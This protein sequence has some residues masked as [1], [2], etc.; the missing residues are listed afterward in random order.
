MPE[1]RTTEATIEQLARWAEHVNICDQFSDTFLGNLGRQCIR[2]FQIDENSRRDWLESLNKAEERFDMKVVEKNYPWPKAANVKYPILAVAVL[3]FAARAYSSIIPSRNVVKGKVLGKDPEGEKRARAERIGEH[4][5]Y[6]LLDVIEDW[7][8]ETDIMVHQLPLA[9]CVFR[10]TF[11]DEAEREPTSEMVTARDLVVNQNTKTLDTVPRITQ[12]F[13]LYPHEIEDR[14]ESDI[15]SDFDFG[16]SPGGDEGDEDSPH[17]FIEQHRLVDLDEDG[18]REPWIVTVHVAS[19]TV[20][21]IKAN[22]TPEDIHTH[23]QEK[24]AIV[25]SKIR[26]RVQYTKYPFLRDPKG[27]FYDLGFGKLL[28]TLS[29]TIDSTLNQLMDAGHLQNSGGG[30]IGSGVQLKRSHIRTRPGKYDV[31]KAPGGNIRNAIVN[32]EHPG[33]SQTL[34]ALLGMLIESAE[35]LASIQDI[36][37]DAMTAQMPA[38]T[39]LALIEQ[40]QKVHTAIYKRIFRALK[41]EFRKLREINKVHLS[42]QEYFRLMDDEQAVA[43]TDYEDEDLDVIPISDPNMTSDTQKLAR[44]QVIAEGSQNPSWGPLHNQYE[45]AHRYYTAASIED[46]DELIQEPPE[47]DPEMQAKTDELTARGAE[48]E[49]AKLEGEAQKNQA[50]AAAKIADAQGKEADREI[51]GAEIEIKRAEAEDRQRQT[52]ITM[53]ELE[54]KREELNLK[55][56]ELDLKARELNINAGKAIGDLAV[57]RAKVDVD[58]KKAGASD[59]AKSEAA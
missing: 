45:A 12:R 47:P 49:V 4:M 23:L 32:H 2:E 25:I 22:F 10:K 28:E 19:S 54:L 6:Q 57:K 11:F 26:R 20:V 21:R 8:E 24:G 50:E 27:G 16:K 42:D 36:T 43:R 38:T 56:Q 33:P 31:V 39:V 48:A 58:D 17:E 41:S 3:Q 29:D 46:I 52:D 9:G 35:R 55:R 51:K 37:V 5:S 59:G 7:E 40:G 14:I 1:T 30:F 53:A 15:Y 44:A 34:Y 13:E 18:V